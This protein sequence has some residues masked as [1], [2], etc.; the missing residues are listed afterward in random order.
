MF[1]SFSLFRKSERPAKP[2]AVVAAMR[3]AARVARTATGDAKAAAKAREELSRLVTA[4]KG[5][6]FGGTAIAGTTGEKSGSAALAAQPSP[7]D[8]A[9]LTRLACCGDLLLLL[10]ENVAVLEF[11][12]RKDAVQIFNNLLRREMDCDSVD[13]DCRTLRDDAPSTGTTGETD[14]TDVVC[15]GVAGVAITKSR[16]GGNEGGTG[17][18]SEADVAVAGDG[19]KP[20]A[21]RLPR[22][23]VDQVVLNGGHLLRALVCGYDD[24]DVAL[25]SGAMLR[26]CLRD[27]TLVK[28]LLE[29][30]MFWR[31]FELVEKSD[32]DVASD[33]FTSFK[34]LLTRHKQVVATFIVAH[35]DR[36]VEQYNELLRSNNY[37][38]RRQ[39]LKLLGEMLMERANFRIMTQYIS[40]ATNLKLVMNLLLDSRRNIQFEA[41]H[42]F[43]V[44]VANPNKPAEIQGI[45]VRNRDRML[46]YLTDFLSDRDD[47]QFQLD[48]QQIVAEIE[49]LC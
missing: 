20:S 2:D 39:S 15:H 43:K 16:T 28:L 22:K 32:F 46:A 45:L 48:R 8:V 13:E 49:S 31:F 14:S 10:A 25:N 4:L 40:S 47:E 34:D 11:E 5:L 37:V 24:S 41:F 33:A 35:L 29:S 7:D 36:F 18:G 3:E 1:S 19:M 12:S 9:A 17:L 21:R 38:T 27:E 23:A 26:E 30:D 42:V 44:F 6:L